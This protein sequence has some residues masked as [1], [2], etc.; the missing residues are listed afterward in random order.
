VETVTEFVRRTQG[1]VIPFVPGWY[2]WVYAHHYLRLEASQLP[3][4]LGRGRTS[5]TTGE[6][7]EVIQLWCALSGEGIESAAEQLADAYL[8]RW[9]LV[10]SDATDAGQADAG[11]AD[12][13]QPDAGQ[14][15]K[16]Q[17]DAGQ[18]DGSPAAERAPRQGAGAPRKASAR[19]RTGRIHKVRRKAVRRDRARTAA[20]PVPAGRRA[21]A[22]S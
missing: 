8:R 20:S 9:G 5:L 11:Q 17:A 21:G 6:A 19:R 7:L 3:A 12:A 14:A 18:A 4:G 22:G 2:P 10:R 15:V 13:A 1:P 16:G